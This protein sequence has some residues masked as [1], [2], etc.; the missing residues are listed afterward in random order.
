MIEQSK[1]SQK[2]SDSTDTTI[3][4]SVQQPETNDSAIMHQ[5]IMMQLMQ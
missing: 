1:E 3:D 2:Q 5:L 4:S